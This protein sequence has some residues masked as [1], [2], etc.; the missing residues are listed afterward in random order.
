M[1]AGPTVKDDED[2]DD[3]EDDAG[4]DDTGGS[5]LHTHAVQSRGCQSL[6]RSLAGSL[7]EMR[8]VLSEWQCQVAFADI[9]NVIIGAVF[10][11]QADLR[12]SRHSFCLHTRV[13]KP[14]KKMNTTR[15]NF[16]LS[17]GVGGDTWPR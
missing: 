13:Q 4:D 3:E 10:T 5:L 17:V 9:R 14:L 1:P 7:S 8:C 16:N 11:R 15:R 12:D 6:A 2:H